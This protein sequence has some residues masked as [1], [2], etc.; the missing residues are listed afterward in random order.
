MSY[1]CFTIY[2]KAL[3]N[4][5]STLIRNFAHAMDEE[6]LTNM[7]KVTFTKEEIIRRVAQVWAPLDQH[8]KD[9]LARNVTTKSLSRNE[10]VYQ[11]GEIS[12]YCYFLLSG[13]LKVC[14]EGSD[15]RNNILRIIGPGE[16]VGIRAVFADECYTT[17]AIALESAVLAVFPKNIML[18]MS[19]T[20]R[21]VGKYFLKL[22]SSLWGQAEQ[23]TISLTH[24]HVRGRLAEALIALKECYGEEASTHYLNVYLSREDLASLSNMTTSNAIRTLSSFAEDGLVETEGKRIKIVREDELREISRLG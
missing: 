18:S 3:I 13:K 9:L 21:S 17:S 8:E 1:L 16:F 10:Y 11:A 12:G 5:M 15:G 24:K 20:C 4:A 14:M 7:G 19:L 22:F 2:F 6:I 23:R